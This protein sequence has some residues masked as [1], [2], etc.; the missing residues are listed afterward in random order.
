MK[1]F[2]LTY[3]I[4]NVH[5]VY[6]TSN[7]TISS[8]QPLIILIITEFYFKSE[9]L[10]LKKIFSE[11]NRIM[12][13]KIICP[14]L[15]YRVHHTTLPMKSTLVC[16]EKNPI[17]QSNPGDFGPIVIY[18]FSQNSFVDTSTSPVLFCF[19]WKSCAK[20]GLSTT[21][22]SFFFL[23]HQSRD[24]MLCPETYKTW[25]VSHLSKFVFR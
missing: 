18:Q 3:K 2:Q 1:S 24:P 13:R 11:L 16:V 17:S 14:C 22:F 8:S 4:I 9:L 12:V 21:L 19:S 15:M 20:S 10:I 25:Q 7:K 6:I 5:T 23:Y